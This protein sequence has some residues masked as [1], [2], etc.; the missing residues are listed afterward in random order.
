[1]STTTTP[2]PAIPDPMASDST[3]SNPTVPAPTTLDPTPLLLSPRTGVLRFLRDV[4]VPAHYPVG[5]RQVASGIA[6]TRTFTPETSDAQGA[7]YAID[8]E[9]AARG[10]AIGEAVE[11][12]SGFV[13][14][15]G[16]PWGT[17]AELRRAAGPD[18]V[19]PGSFA[20][21]SAAQHAEPGFPF[22]PL[23]DETPTRWATAQALDDGPTALVPA[24]MAW[25][26]PP[27]DAGPPLHGVLQAG[28]AAGPS[29]RSAVWSG[30]CEV[31]E[32]DAMTLGWYGRGGLHE[33]DV[34]EDLRSL[35]A[36]PEGRLAAT[37]WRFPHPFGP[38]VIG[39]FLRDR[40]TGL[41]ALGMGCRPTAG[42]AAGKALTEACQLLLLLDDYDD[43]HGPF[44][45]AARHAGS[46]LLPWRA[47]RDYARG[48]GPEL[49]DARD[50]GCHLQLALDPAIL[51]A[52]EL[53]L[54]DGRLPTESLAALDAAPPA[55]LEGTVAR[56]SAAGHRALAVDLTTP[57]VRR[58]GLHVVRVVVPG[59]YGNAPVGRPFLGGARLAATLGGDVGW[60]RRVPLPH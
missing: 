17:A 4:P 6:R 1:M 31:L 38:P 23:T 10:A 8:D 40:E 47:A 21:Y 43:E 48:Y 54:Q 53:G 56:L 30:L 35:A 19:A 36:G 37:W 25:A 34:G 18:P 2:G 57:D 22:A 33:V 15:R 58:A 32:R 13:V 51:R 44:A 29:W 20:L 16:L 39:A 60:R 24:S 46:P 5:F 12:Y 52:V 55:D 7:G 45:A 50:Y 9:A 11:R 41:V 27:R 42:D 59:L 14:P 3:T 26:V 49:Q 28:L